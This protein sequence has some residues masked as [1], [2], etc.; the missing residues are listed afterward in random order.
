MLFT[1]NVHSCVL[2]Y[3][4]IIASNINHSEQQICLLNKL[5]LRVNSDQCRR[6]F[7]E[8]TYSRSDK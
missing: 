5:M 6:I 4:S 2:G 1:A 7:G 8:F 3:I